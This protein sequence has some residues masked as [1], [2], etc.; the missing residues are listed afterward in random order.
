M[1]KGVYDQIRNSFHIQDLSGKHKN[2][3]ME[4]INEFL[5]IMNKNF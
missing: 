3:P 4:K 1:D 5:D 2:N